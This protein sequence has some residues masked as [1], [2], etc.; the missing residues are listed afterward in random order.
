MGLITSVKTG[1]S[2]KITLTYPSP[3]LSSQSRGTPKA[4]SPSPI[5]ALPPLSTAPCLLHSLLPFPQGH[6][7]QIA[8]NPLQLESPSATSGLRRIQ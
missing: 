1:P 8:L 3:S 2:Q 5:L 7:V 6:L 4:F